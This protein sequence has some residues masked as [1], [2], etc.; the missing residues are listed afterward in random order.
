M[1]VT[2]AAEVCKNFELSKEAEALLQPNMMPRP[3]LDV[4][5]ANQ[6]YQDAA[7][8]MAHAMPKRE[9]VWWACLCARQ[10]YGAAP[11]AKE[12]TVLQLAETW[13][14]KPTDENRRAAHQA[15]EAAQFKNPAGLIGM[16]IFFS[17][18]S[19]G[20]PGQAEVPPAPPLCG[21]AVGNSVILATVLK[22][23]AKANER[24]LQF[25][26]LGFEVANGKNRWK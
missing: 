6:H 24:Y 19:L 21:N 9:A 4:L 23:P 11:P 18:G 20:P 10:A 8:F 2:T 25:F 12:A 16:A 1:A 15:A 13:V 26:A 5:I 17:S 3:F 14:S 7:K 22:E